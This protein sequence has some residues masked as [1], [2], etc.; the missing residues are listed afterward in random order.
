MNI[1]DINEIL[2][3]AI[4]GWNVFGLPSLIVFLVFL[5]FRNS[6]DTA[7]RESQKT[8]TS[9]GRVHLALAF[10]S[11]TTIVAELWA[12][13][14]MADLLIALGLLRRSRFLRWVAIF[15]SLFRSALAIY[16]AVWFWQYAHRIDWTEWPRD[17]LY[18]LFP[19]FEIVVLL[20]P[21]TSR[22]FRKTASEEWPSSETRFP[23]LSTCTLVFFTVGLSAG[24][25]DA[26]DWS[27]RTIAEIYVGV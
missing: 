20:A 11:L 18:W 14:T 23:L 19:P 15:W 8:V 21:S 16:V 1:D 26:V 22:A 27:I 13:R 7:E 5:S 6:S 17:L 4:E 12:Y 2:I 10:W 25:T 3:R 24:L 9:L